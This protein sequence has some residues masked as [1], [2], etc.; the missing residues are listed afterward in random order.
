LAKHPAGS[1]NPA[2]I[3]ALTGC[4]KTY[5]FCHS[6]RSEESLFDLK[7]ENKEREILR[8][9]QNDKIKHFFRRLLS[10]QAS[11]TANSN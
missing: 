11:A 8:S 4:G 6:E 9:A 5:H 10:P 1:R 7:V 3:S 2:A